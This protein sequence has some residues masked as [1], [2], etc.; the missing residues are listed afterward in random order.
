[1]NTWSAKRSTKKEIDMGV[2]DIVSRLDKED[3]LVSKVR[4]KTKALSGYGSDGVDQGLDVAAQKMASTLRELACRFKK[5]GLPG[6]TRVSVSSNILA[7]AVTLEVDLDAIEEVTV[8]VEQPDA[9]VQ[10][11]GAPSN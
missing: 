6:S 8:N 2:R 4:S 10:S 3:S 5:Q 7:F 11:E 9:E 1:M